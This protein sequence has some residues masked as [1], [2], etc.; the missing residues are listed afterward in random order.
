M[1]HKDIYYRG[2][3]GVGTDR[4]LQR[5]QAAH[6]TGQGLVK[7]ARAV[8]EGDW[9][10]ERLAMREWLGAGR[11]STSASVLRGA[12]GHQQARTDGVHV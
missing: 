12:V 2:Y 3:Y 9:W 8:T 7:P 1:D 4:V 5:A 11:R 10:R 6:H